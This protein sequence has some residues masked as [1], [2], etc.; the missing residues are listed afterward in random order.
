MEH[1]VENDSDAARLVLE[2]N[3][4]MTRAIVFSSINS[5]TWSLGFVNFTISVHLRSS[6][7]TTLCDGLL[8]PTHYSLISS[9]SSS[10][11]G[12]RN[13]TH[14]KHGDNR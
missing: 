4:C 8:L 5:T 3:K 6:W 10:L 13:N 12:I 7:S 14:T 2:L 9:L 11:H 1:V